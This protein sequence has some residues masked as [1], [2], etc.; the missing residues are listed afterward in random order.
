MCNQ[1]FVAD[2]KAHEEQRQERVLH[3]QSEAFFQR[4]SR[5]LPRQEIAEFQADF[6]M[7]VRAIYADAA[8]GP[9]KM[10]TDIVG[11]VVAMP[12]VVVVCQG[13]L[14]RPD[15]PVVPPIRIVHPGDGY[16]GPPSGPQVRSTLGK[17]G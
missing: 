12:P 3:L 1:E 9:Q 17:E 2:M 6:H 14:D 11:R 5:G 8:R 13:G 16:T 7:I 10:L 15:G 4:W